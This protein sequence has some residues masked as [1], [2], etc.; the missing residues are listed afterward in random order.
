MAQGQAGE[1]LEMEDGGVSKSWR[2]ILVRALDVSPVIDGKDMLS[3]RISN[4]L[5]NQGFKEMG[6]VADFLEENPRFV[7]WYNVGGK[8]LVALKA[9]IATQKDSDLRFDLF[10]EKT[11]AQ[12]RELARLAQEARAVEVAR[13]D[14]LGKAIQQLRREI[15]RAS[16]PAEM[17]RVEFVPSAGPNVEFTGKLL[18]QG[19]YETGGRDP[20]SVQMEVWQTQGGAYVAM[21]CANPSS[22]DGIK[23]T[24]VAVVPAQADALAMRCAVMDLFDWNNRARAMMRKAQDWS[25]KLEVD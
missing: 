3:A 18:A 20:L 8:S 13:A 4:S 15:K 23:V 10:D 11:L 22:R 14:A 2:Q 12:F 7:G 25:F 1:L 5:L 6:E 16:V 9:W 19:R 24:E 21:R 17:E